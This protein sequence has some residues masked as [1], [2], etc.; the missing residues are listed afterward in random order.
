LD[1]GGVYG[2]L[3]HGSQKSKN[4]GKNLKITS[5]RTYSKLLVLCQFKKLYGNFQNPRTGGCNKIKEP[6]PHWCRQASFES[7]VP[8][9]NQTKRSC[10]FHSVVTWVE[11]GQAC[12][13]CKY[14]RIADSRRFGGL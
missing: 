10:N 1:K 4:P 7:Y 14:I 2:R 12:P 9:K 13:K 11:R 5:Q 3:E 6:P 8:L